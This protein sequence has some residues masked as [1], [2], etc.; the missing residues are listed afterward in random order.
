MR[1]LWQGLVNGLLVLMLLG[2]G[3]PAPRRAIAQPEVAGLAASGVYEEDFS[4]YAGKDYVDQAVWDIG[5]AGLRL[6]RL[7]RIKQWSPVVAANGAGHIFVVWYDN[8]NGGQDI[9]AQRLD[10]NG[11]RLWA[12]DVR[13][14]SNNAKLRGWSPT[15]AVDGNG[16]AVVVWTDD[17]N[18][19]SNI[20]AQRLDASGNQLWAEDVRVD[21]DSGMVGYYGSP[22][23]VAADSSGNAVVVW[24]DYRNGDWDLYA[25]RLDVNGNRL[26]A[27]DMRV[28]SDSGTALQVGPD[29]AVDGSGNAVVV[30]GDTR[31]GDTDVYMQRL[32]VGGNRLW[33]QDMRVN[34]DSGT[35]LQASPAVVADGSGNVVVVWSE[36]RNG[37]W[38]DV[39]IYAQ[40]LDTSGNRLWVEDKR[41]NGNGKI[42]MTNIAAPA[43]AI[44]SNGNAV[45]VWGNSNESLHN[46]IYAQRL[47]VSGNRLWVQ[48]EQV[49]DANRA[50]NHWCPTVVVDSGGNALVV[51]EDQ[52]NGDIYAQRLN[53]SGNR[54]GAQDAR[55]NDDSGTARQAIPTTAVN[56]NGSAIVVWCDDRNGDYNLYAQRLDVSGNSLWAQD[57]W[58]NGDSGTVI[59][60][61]SAVAVDSSG[62]AVVV[63]A[64]S[65]NGN[66]DI[67]AQR[68]D[69]DGNR[70]WGSDVRVNSDTG[71]AGQYSPAVAMDSNGNA[72]MVWADYRNGNYDI[73]AQQ[74]DGDGNR[75]WGSDV[76]VN[77]DTGT[78]GQYSPAIAVDGNGNNVVVWQDYRNGNG[79]IYAQR[80]DGAG[81]RLWGSDVRVNSDTGTAGLY[82]PAIAVDGNGNNV[83]VWQDYRNGNGDIYAQRLDGAGNR[84]WGSDVRVNSDTGTAGQYSPAVAMDSNG[85]AVPVWEDYRNGNYD[86]YAQRLDANGNQ[87][88]AEDVQVNGDSRIASQYVPV[89]AIDGSGNAM[90]MWQ[91]NRNGND[92]IYAQR[93]NTNGSRLWSADLQVILPD[94]FLLSHWHCPIPHCGHPH[95]R[96]HPGHPHRQYDPRR[97]QRAI[98]SHQQRRRDLG[99]R[100]PRHH[101]HFQHHRLRSAL[102]GRPHR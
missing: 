7:D 51:W 28:N 4:T 90:V 25:Q 101:A 17:H 43:M 48:D 86:I 52:A 63:W 55:V 81:N 6:E 78:A 32:D 46:Q 13:V 26:W 93:L 58:V 100:H 54:L 21:R 41:V 65:R 56:G 36:T 20:Y 77:S 88:W 85:N 59:Q 91:D 83:V 22:P 72:V 35:A 69:G 27:Q 45:V 62:N 70:L 18:G 40:R 95:R 60:R 79:D 33:A 14:N 82:S 102:A 31:N 29:V 24:D 3:V 34:G 57:V 38:D 97:R 99:R 9:Y 74:L 84:L 39:D 37:D 11:N 12:E 76:R 68:L 19:D 1:K 96:H 10:A 50:A 92:D 47:D 30:W 80:L 71:T 23:A 5:I 98:L 67:Y 2:M 89:V 64:D 16:N 8:R 87:L 73:Y 75:L 53:T 66:D 42:T 61:Y 15:V 44:D 49:N 94:F